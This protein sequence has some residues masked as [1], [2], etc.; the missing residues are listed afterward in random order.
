[1]KLK[2]FLQSAGL[3]LS[4]PLSW[5][6]VVAGLTALRGNH[7]KSS[8]RP[9]PVNLTMMCYDGTEPRVSATFVKDH[10]YNGFTFSIYHVS[11]ENC[12]PD[13]GR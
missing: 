8:P 3:L 1:V 5:V 4:L 9:L 10:T 6:I 12:V 11:V 7:E 2:R 13:E